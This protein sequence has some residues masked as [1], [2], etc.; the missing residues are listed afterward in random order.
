MVSRNEYIDKYIGNYWH[1]FTDYEIG[2]IYGYPTTCIQAFVKMLERYDVPDNEI[3]KFYTQ[4]MIFIGCGWYSKDFFEQEKEHYDR[5]WEQIRN[6]SPTLV[7]QAEE[8]YTTM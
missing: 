4:A 5:I 6:I 3:M 7:E 2:I 8:E 1:T